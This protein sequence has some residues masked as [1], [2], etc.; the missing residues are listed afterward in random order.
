M[1]DISLLAADAQAVYTED[2]QEV[3]IMSLGSQISS[4]RKQVNLTQSQL[5]EALDVSFQA[6]SSWE[7]D[8]Y[9]PDTSRLLLLAQVL[10]TTVGVLLE[11]FARPDWVTHERLFD[12]Q[13]MYTFVKSAAVAKGLPQVLAVLPRMKKWHSGQLRVGREG[14]PYIIHPLTMSCHALALG[15]E[16]DDVIVTILLH[17]VVEDCGV[18][19][20]E[21]PVND[22]VQTAVQL[23]SYPP[24][25]DMKTFRPMYYERIGNNATA[26]LVKCLDRC[27]N[28]S[29]MASGFSREKMASYIVE[30]EIY[31]FPLLQQLKETWVQYNSVSWLLS[32]QIKSLL[33]VYKRIL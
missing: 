28:L 32:Y 10:H 21:L 31:L 22:E 7:R 13:H 23:L 12:E 15:I 20:E 3:E 1:F 24:I 30:T 6:V 27:N 9:Q 5:A 17:D 18:R 2:E 8:E 16:D 11:E 19:V 14:V 4:F 33:E 29:T 26:C 25:V